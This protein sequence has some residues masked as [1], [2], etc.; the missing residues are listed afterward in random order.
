[1]GLV[2]FLGV[3]EGHAGLQSTKRALRDSLEE[4]QIA[5]KLFVFRN[6]LDHGS[7]REMVNKC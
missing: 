3:K 5:T 4:F 6:A 1:M 2:G 7:Q